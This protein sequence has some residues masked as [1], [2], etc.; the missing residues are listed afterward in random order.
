[1]FRYW[2]LTVLRSGES[3]PPKVELRLARLYRTAFSRQQQ[4]HLGLLPPDPRSRRAANKRRAYP[5]N[6]GSLPEHKNF[7][8]VTEQR[9]FV[10]IIKIDQLI[11]HAIRGYFYSDYPYK[12]CLRS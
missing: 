4:R 5:E 11:Y 3:V 7:D 2:L 8:T 10:K 1:M 6:R 9:N 12:K